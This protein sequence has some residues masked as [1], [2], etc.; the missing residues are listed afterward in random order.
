M[1]A[2]SA[3]IIRRHFVFYLL[4]A[5][6]IV[7]WETINSLR[8]LES[9]THTGV[10]VACAFLCANLPQ[11]VLQGAPLSIAG[12]FTRAGAITTGLKVAVIAAVLFSFTVYVSINAYE[13]VPAGANLP[14]FDQLVLAGLLVIVL[15]MIV[16]FL[17]SWIPAG[18]MKEKVG[19]LMAFGR[20]FVSIHTVYWR[21]V[22]AL[23][24]SILLSFLIL[25]AY[26]LTFER[27]PSMVTPGGG[28]DAWSIACWYLVSLVWLAL[29]TYVNVVVCVCYA[30]AEK[31]DLGAIPEATATQS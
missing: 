18:I 5:L 10:I 4:M 16:T 6:L 25:F 7:T 31:I 12:G 13:T 11:V 20:G 30:R 29:L 27:E 9:S 14:L 8:L 24:A 21:L 1:L 2:K 19:L 22:L 15:P 23:G 3:R 17:G 26:L 28:I